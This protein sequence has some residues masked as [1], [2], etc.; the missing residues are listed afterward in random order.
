MK[1]TVS[2]ENG[3]YVEEYVVNPRLFSAWT[4]QHIQSED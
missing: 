3:D 1:K 2:E 4:F